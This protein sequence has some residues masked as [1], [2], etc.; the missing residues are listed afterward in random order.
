MCRG[1]LKQPM[2]YM[3]TVRPLVP[4]QNR[5]MIELNSPC[6]H[7]PNNTLCMHAMKTLTRLVFAK[8]C[9]SIHS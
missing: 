8:A 3:A 2:V 7:G 5:L 1:F 9:P 6:A 4:I